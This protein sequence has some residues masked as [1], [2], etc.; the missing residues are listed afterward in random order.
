MSLTPGSMLTLSAVTS[1][2]SM[3]VFN[4]PVLELRS[5]I[6]IIGSS[7]YALMLTM[8]SVR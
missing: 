1:S 6:N 4:I 8:S 2:M 5:P 7:C 3:N